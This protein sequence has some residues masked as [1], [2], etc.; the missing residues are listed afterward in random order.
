LRTLRVDAARATDVFEIAAGSAHALARDAA[1]A[2]G[3]AGALA[4]GLLA[5]RA[6]HAAWA[7]R[8]FAGAALSLAVLPAG[9]VAFAA[10][11]A[12]RRVRAEVGVDGV[13][14]RNAYGRST[15]Y[16]FERVAALDERRLELVLTDRAGGRAPFAARRVDEF[17]G[18][19]Q[20]LVEAFALF[21]AAKSGGG[22]WQVLLPP[23][24]VATPD[25]LARLRALGGD[26]AQGYRALGIE[27]ARLLA[28]AESPSVPPLGRAA[29]A[30]V[31]FERLAPGELE[32]V[33]AAAE[34][35]AHAGLRAALASVVRGDRVE[36]ARAMAGLRAVASGAWGEL[37]GARR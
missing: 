6:L 23:E 37:G 10:W 26:G 27:R 17:D 1:I 36:T 30:F 28:L 35:S 34:T 19:A 18:F 3:A 24:G 7:P 15:F 14:T 25:W 4:A 29:A 20:R 12:R 5:A 31:L 16:P 11:A 2:A 8:G 21:R 33:R 22:G 32:R 9:A 13:A